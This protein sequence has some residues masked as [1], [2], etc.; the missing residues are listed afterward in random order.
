MIRVGTEI[1][2]TRPHTDDFPNDMWVERA[3]NYPRILLRH[4]QVLDAKY[5]VFKKYNLLD[6]PEHLWNCE[7]T[8]VGLQGRG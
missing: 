8:V 1:T 2:G 7:V 6:K 4:V 3:A 5:T